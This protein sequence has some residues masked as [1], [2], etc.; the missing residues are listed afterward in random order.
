MQ[1][2]FGILAWFKPD[3]HRQTLDDFHVVTSRILGRREAEPIATRTRHVLH[4]AAIVAPE[5]IDT[6]RHRLAT[7]H[8]GKLRL[9]KVC[10]HPDVVRLSHEPQGLPWLN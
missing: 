8:A 3:S 4:V 9:L 7:V 1:Q 6:N 5:R 10:R 2:M